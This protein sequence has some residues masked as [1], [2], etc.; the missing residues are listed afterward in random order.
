MKTQQI[1]NRAMKTLVITAMLA[2]GC[3]AALAQDGLRS[4]YFL[5][6]YSYQHRMNP[7]I[8]GERNYVSFPF[9][10]GNINVG[11]QSTMGV[12][13]FLYKTQSGQLTTFMNE[14]V[15][16][17]SFLSGL[18]NR[19]VTNVD[20]TY[21][22]MSAGFFKF[23]GFNTVELNLRSSTSL[24]TPKDLFAFMKEGMSSSNTYY[25]IG[26]LGLSSM[27]YAEIAFGHSRKVLDNL[28]VGAKV[29]VLIGLAQASAKMKDLQV[30]MTEDKWEVQSKGEM[31]IGLKGLSMPSKEEAGR[32]Y[33]DELGE[34]DLIS[35]DDID[36]GSYGLNGGGLAFDLG[37]TYKFRDD[38]EF[39]A[40][41][42]DIGFIKWG[43]SMIAKTADDTW[44]FDGFH[45]IG[46]TGDSDNQL[47]DQLDDLGD[48][49]ADFFNFHKTS[50]TKGKARALGATLTLGALYTPPFYDGKLKGGFL[51]T[52][53]IKG[54]YTWTEGRFSANWYPCNVFDMSVNYG[55][56]NFGSSFGWVAN[57]HTK[58]INFFVGSDHMFFKITPQFVPVHRANTNVSIGINF[59]FGAK[60]NI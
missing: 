47:D 40:A 22:I 7:A 57:V 15:S 9:V 45:E 34:G 38:L 2:L 30:R 28:N 5:D 4:A 53:R 18:K 32:S 31:A 35:W 54:S 25:D 20:L 16:A 43:S 26:N 50:K 52:T 12:S 6:G 1:N 19:N 3:T 48:E 44:M 39:S 42:T 49:L 56:S 51:W 33:D 60:K 55:V 23:G 21:N 46:M 8:A 14:C 17:N 37:A 11:A 36:M 59:P 13:N 10:L 29:K 24:N 27:T 58:G 41:I